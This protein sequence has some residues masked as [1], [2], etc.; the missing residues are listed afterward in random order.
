MDAVRTFCSKVAEQKEWEIKKY[1]PKIQ[2]CIRYIRAHLHYPVSLEEVSEYLGVNPKYLSRNFFSETGL[3][4]SD[5]IRRERVKEA[6]VLLSTSD[7]PYIDIA[8]S[9]AFSSQ[10]YFIKVFSE[11]MGVTPRKYR[12]NG[13][14]RF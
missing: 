12:E 1:S 7:M 6:C 3:K 5:F 9:L 2:R 13:Q 11:I 4:F 8:N 10:S 14:T